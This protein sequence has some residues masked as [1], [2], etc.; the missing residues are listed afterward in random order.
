MSAVVSPAAAP[1]PPLSPERYAALYALRKAAS[2][3]TAH[4]IGWLC[5]RAPAL[6]GHRR[7]CRVLS[8]GTGEGDVDLALLDAFGAVGVEA[9]VT[10]LEPSAPQRARLARRLADRPAPC[11]VTVQP[12][13]FEDFAACGTWDLVLI[14]QSAYY[15]DATALPALLH[16]AWA[17]VAAGGSLVIAHQSARG[18]PEVQARHLPRLRGTWDHVLNGDDLHQLLVRDRRIPYRPA[19]DRHAVDA[20]LDLR[21]CLDPGSAEGLDILSFCLECDL[22]GVPAALQEDVRQTVAALA[23]DRGDGPRLVEPVDVFWVPRPGEGAAARG[24]GARR[25]GAPRQR[26]PQP[27]RNR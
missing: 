8:L 11:R 12:T 21:R 20:S 13:R 6:A 18:V 3:Q 2:T 16:R 24:P 25:I 26:Q 15:L 27:R 5:A 17:R 19:R 7:T 9:H 23:E 4:T 22:S 10:A 1:A 14:C